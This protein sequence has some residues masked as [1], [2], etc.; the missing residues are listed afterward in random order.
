MEYELR[1]PDFGMGSTGVFVLAPVDGGQVRVTW[2]DAGSVGGNPVHRWFA[3]FIDRIV[4]PSFEQ[5]L[6]K[7]KRVSEAPSP[8]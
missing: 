4:G 7:L 2:S 6:A 8:R 5:G 1:F 3:L